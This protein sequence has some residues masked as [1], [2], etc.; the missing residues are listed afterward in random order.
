MSARSANDRCSDSCAGDRDF[1]QSVIVLLRSGVSSTNGPLR[2]PSNGS[3]DTV[4]SVLGANDETR[5]IK[6]THVYRSALSGFAANLTTGQA[7]ALSTDP[8]VEA[9]VP[10]HL[11]H[12]ADGTIE[13]TANA[14]ALSNEPSADPSS[15]PS[16]SPSASPSRSIGGPS[17]PA[18]GQRPGR[19][20]RRA[21]LRRLQ[22]R[23]DELIRPRTSVRGR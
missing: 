22:R 12:V 5:S 17:R 14:N 11:T 7:Q 10:N 1:Y 6:P 18:A 9:I 21:P 20:A 8:R 4:A 16:S 19:Q 13:E 2:M 23:G 15:Q 3:A